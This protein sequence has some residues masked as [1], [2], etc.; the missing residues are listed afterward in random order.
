VHA[1]EPGVKGFR[2][3]AYTP[4]GAAMAIE[5]AET[6]RFGVQF[7]PESILTTQGGAGARIIANVLRLCARHG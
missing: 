3:T 7:H 4:D 2:V 6:L 5:D 1:K